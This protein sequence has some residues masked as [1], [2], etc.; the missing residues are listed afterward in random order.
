MQASSRNRIKA[1]FFVVAVDAELADGR[2][3]PDILLLFQQMIA[4][5]K[6]LKNNLV[7]ACACVCG[8]VFLRCAD[9]RKCA[10]LLK[11]LYVP[12]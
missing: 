7:W 4:K 2:G 9:T 1:H 5:E 10:L 8:C 3:P 12:I 11:E 6:K